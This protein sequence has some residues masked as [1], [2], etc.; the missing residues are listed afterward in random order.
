MDEVDGMAGNEDRGGIAEL[1]QLIKDSNVPVICMCNDRNHQKMRSLVNHCFDLRFQKPKVEQIRGAMMTVCFKEGMKLPAAVID[2]IIAGTGNDVR[3]T[4]N[5][6]AM[7]SAGNTAKLDVKTA[8]TN[9]EKAKKDV[10]IGSW[11]VIR[12]VFSAEEQKDM[13]MNDKSDLFFHDYSLAPLF[14]QENYLK[15]VPRAPKSEHLDLIAKTA[16]SLSFGDMVEKRIRS[17]MSWSLLP[18]QAMFSSVI[19]GELMSGHY[20]GQISFPGWLGKNSKTNKRKR[21]AQEIHDHTRVKTSG[22]RLSVR[23]DYAQFL[24]AAILRPLKLKGMEGVEE[25]LAIIKE[26]KLLREDIDSLIELTSWPRKKGMWDE[27]DGKVKAALTRAYNKEVQPYTYSVVNAVKKK[28]AT[29][30]LEAEE[31]NELYGEE[32]EGATQVES[33]DEKEDDNLENN[34]FIKVKKK[35]AGSAG[36]SAKAGSSKAAAKPKKEPKE[37]AGTSKGRKK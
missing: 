33:D 12:K 1:I 22:S 13:T 29:A 3:Q 24:L 25:S 14:V 9:A 16:D 28:K 17:N 31:M 36:S 10:K 30:N 27:I 23:M 4:L 18:V 7:Y 6:L 15:V 5:H 35:G 21:L 8:K 26:Y 11:D 32:G 37:K 20:N 34:A 2:E 19:P